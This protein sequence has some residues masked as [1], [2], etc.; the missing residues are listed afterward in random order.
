[1]ATDWYMEGPYVKNCNCDPGCPC[2]FNQKP[3]HGDCEGM[4]AMRIDQ[5]RFGDVDLSGLCW[6]VLVSL[7]GAPARGQRRHPADHRRARRTRDRRDA[8]LQAMSGQHGDTFFEIVAF[9]APNVKDPIVAPA[10]FE[11][12]LE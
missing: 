9:I 1:M 3:T 4:A 11:F 7:A 5:G 10:E 12:D 8:L 6:G 2:D